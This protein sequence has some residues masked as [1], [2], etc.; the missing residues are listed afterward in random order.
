MAE[1]KRYRDL[2]ADSAR[3]DGFVM[4]PGD[5]VVC[6]P[7]KCGTTWMQMLCA[8]LLHDT[9]ELDRPLPEISPW[10]DMKTTP[11]EEVLATLQAQTHRRLIK[12]HTPLD[13]LPIDAA[14]TYVCVARDPRDV[15]ISWEHHWANLDKD[16]LM[17]RLDEAGGLDDLAELGPAP[18]PAATDPVERFWQWADSGPGEF[19]GPTLAQVL[20]HVQTFWDHRQDPNVILFHYSDMLR[21][22]PGQIRRLAGA[23]SID[24]TE[25]RVAEL[26]AATTFAAMKA[27]ADVL[28]PD[29]DHA[30]WFDNSAF[31]HAGQSGQWRGLLDEAGQGSY[32]DRVAALVAPDLAAWVHR[33]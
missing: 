17:A 12:T 18:A 33:D 26:A 28:I 32:R 29:V 9:L 13:G 7:A 20:E 27:R 16:V 31:F 14:V 10:L 6:T 23:L 30:V 3:W 22:L 2:V 8:L 15:A 21:D 5:V 25:R 11:R 24:V 19:A 1:L 4:R